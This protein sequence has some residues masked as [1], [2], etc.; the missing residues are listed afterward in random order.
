MWW[1]DAG[2]E[3]R[4]DTTYTN[5]NALMTGGGAKKGRKETNTNNKNTFKM[6]WRGSNENKW[7]FIFLERVQDQRRSN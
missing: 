6:L 5:F 7:V 1:F 3:L 2:Q 4:I